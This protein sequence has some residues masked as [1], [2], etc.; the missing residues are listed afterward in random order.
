MEALARLQ[1]LSRPSGSQ[2][3]AR[4]STALVL[5]RASK[6]TIVITAGRKSCPLSRDAAGK[7]GSLSPG[8][9]KKTCLMKL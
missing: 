3:G 8:A 5:K 7:S 2:K 9:S 1:A 6:W 4:P